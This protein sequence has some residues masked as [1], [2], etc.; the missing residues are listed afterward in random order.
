[1][2]MAL[3]ASAAVG[4]GAG[5]RGKASGTVQLHDGS[6]LVGGLVIARSEATGK[7]ATGQTDSQGHYQLSTSDGSD[8]PAGD[9]AVIIQERRQSMDGPVSRLVP[10]R[11]SNPAT[12]GLS[13]SVPAGG[14]VTLDVKL[15]RP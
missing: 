15:D 11:Y 13:V 10:P 5:D 7:A 8:I 9:Y 14:D 1:M 2:A 4:C 3:A 12:S 6:P